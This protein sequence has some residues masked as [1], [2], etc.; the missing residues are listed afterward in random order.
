[1]KEQAIRIRTTSTCK[2]I[3]LCFD[4]SCV[5][6]HLHKGFSCAIEHLSCAF[7]ATISNC[8]NKL[9]ENH[10]FYPQSLESACAPPRLITHHSSQKVELQM[11]YHTESNKDKEGI[12]YKPPTFQKR[13]R[14][15]APTNTTKLTLKNSYFSCKERIKI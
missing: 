7:K 14:S 10:L 12:A 3:E 2:I 4:W 8:T 9:R 13:R 6:S 1:M 5:L 11:S 15:T